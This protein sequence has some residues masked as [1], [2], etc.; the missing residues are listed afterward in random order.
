M[1]SD[2]CDEL[3]ALFFLGNIYDPSIP[4]HS[5]CQCIDMDYG[6]G[7]DPDLILHG[8]SVRIL[9]YS[10]ENILNRST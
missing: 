3:S 5:S 7:V 4:S 1:A 10:F 9:I 6:S 2:R 8:I